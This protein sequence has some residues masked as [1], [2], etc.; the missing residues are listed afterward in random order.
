MKV[1]IIGGGINGLYLAWKLS[2]KGYDVIVFERKKQIGDNII[3][4]GLFS[5][6]IL[7]II[8][9]SQKLI[10]N[11][12]NYANIHFPKKTIRVDF[13]KPFFIIDHSELD[14]LVASL[15]QSQGARLL[16]NQNTTEIPED[17]D[18]IIGCDGANSVIRKKLNLK[19]P[20]FRLGILEIR[21]GRTS[22]DFVDVWPCKTGFSW[23][24][25]RGS[26]VELGQIAD[27][28]EIET[29]PGLVS[30]V[31]PQGLVVP[32]NNKVT[33]CG[34]AAGLTKPWSGGGVIWGLFAANMLL[35]AFPDF[36]KY[37]KKTK[38]FFVPKIILS[39]IAMKL[40]YFFG[41]NTPWVL[42]K[43]ARIESDFLL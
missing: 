36:N 8:P 16:L 6:R 12:I 9:Q 25:P 13:S 11:R 17:F 40:I 20:K 1:A 41:N 23:R 38:K 28:K 24:I 18:K 43:Q 15:A 29:R 10:Q 22:A 19:Y 7:D 5:Q 4:S 30:K 34:D 39:K 26:G 37:R 35:E 32:K 21:G 2:G 3:C 33:L 27:P 31:I 14:K 42:P